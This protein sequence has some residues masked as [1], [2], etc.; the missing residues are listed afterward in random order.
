MAFPVALALG[1]GSRLVG[2]IFG[3]RSRQRQQ[4]ADFANQQSALDYQAALRNQQFD[5]D[6]QR[7]AL[8]G[9]MFRGLASAMGMGN[10]IPSG[11]TNFSTTARQGVQAPRLRDGGTGTSLWGDIFNQAGS[12]LISRDLQNR[13]AGASGGGS[14]LSALLPA[15]SAAAS[16][17]TYGPTP[18]DDYEAPVNPYVSGQIGSGFGGDQEY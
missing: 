2:S 5:V 17:Q 1:L 8:R 11:Y 16:G 9:S 12:A 15:T 3:N 6:E 13:V 10:L 7:R 14:P 18:P 4:Q